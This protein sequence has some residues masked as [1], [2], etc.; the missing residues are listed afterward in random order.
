MDFYI[1]LCSPNISRE[2]ILLTI[3][4][5]LLQ[6]RTDNDFLVQDRSTRGATLLDL[7][8]INTEE[9]I[10]EVNIRGSL[11]C[12]T[13]DE[14]VFLRNVG[15]ANIGG[16]TLKFRRPSFRSVKELLDQIPWETRVNKRGPAGQT[17]GN[18]GK[19]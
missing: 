5:R 13:L 17:E 1:H 4:F 15:L 8:L 19:T 14:F 2:H 12:S 7:V 18:K 6:E 16:R 3:E 9:F 10:I 11:G